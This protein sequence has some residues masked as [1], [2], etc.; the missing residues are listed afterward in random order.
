MASEYPDAVRRPDVC[1][2]I[3]GRS[4][5]AIAL[6]D[7]WLGS[8]L[9]QVPEPVHKTEPL[10]GHRTMRGRRFQCAICEIFSRMPS[11]RGPRPGDFPDFARR[12]KGIGSGRV[13]DGGVARW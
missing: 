1:Q 7:P 9:C 8:D 13:P 12:V 3:L 4:R 5:D 10:S 6:A 2:R 11:A